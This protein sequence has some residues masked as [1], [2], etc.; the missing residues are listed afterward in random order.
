MPNQALILELCGQYNKDFWKIDSSAYASKEAY[1]VDNKHKLSVSKFTA[2]YIYHL[3]FADYEKLFKP[4]LIPQPVA[5]LGLDS[6]PLKTVKNLLSIFEAT[7][8]K[9]GVENL[10]A[11]SLEFIYQFVIRHAKS[12]RCITI[13][14]GENIKN[15]KKKFLLHNESVAEMNSS[16]PA[17]LVNMGFQLAR[18]KETTR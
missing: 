3:L 17:V 11:S 15:Y 1:I 9:I 2:I 7:L 12:G 18:P 10:S 6:L 5:I 14:C 16:K 8:V 4:S 13:C